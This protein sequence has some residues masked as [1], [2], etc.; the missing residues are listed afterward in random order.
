[1]EKYCL[2]QD[3]SS[4]WYVIPVSKRE[5]WNTW[6]NLPED[7]EKSWE[8]PDYAERINSPFSITFDSFEE[9]N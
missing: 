1:M 2:E 8:A 7:D 3:Q 9:E 4:H 5:H 6:V